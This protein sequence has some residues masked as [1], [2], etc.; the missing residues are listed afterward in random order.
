M[1]LKIVGELM[2]KY[3]WDEYYKKFYDWSK[4]KRAN[5]LHE[6]I[7]LGSVEEVGEII[8][9][10][11]ENISA[12]NS[13]LEKAVKAKLVF[14]GSYLRE[15]ACVNDK[16]LVAEATLNSFEILN[17]DE[18]ADILIE[19]QYSKSAFNRVLEKAVE[20]KIIFSAYSLRE[21]TETKNKKLV[22]DAIVNSLERLNADEVGEMIIELEEDIAASN[23]VLK[24]AV[25]EKLAFSGTH[26]VYFLYI[27]N[28]K[29]VGEAAINSMKR[30]N[31]NEVEEI[32][33]EFENHVSLTNRL[34]KKVVEAKLSLSGSCLCELV[35]VNNKNLVA[36]VI[37]NSFER[38]SADEIGE[39]IV[40]L[41]ENISASNKVLKQ[42]V[43]TKIVFSSA[44][45]NDFLYENDK[46]LVANATINSMSQLATDE[47]GKIIVELQDTISSSNRV[48]KKRLKQSI[49]FLLFTSMIFCMKIIRI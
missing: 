33:S 27:N 13:L 42:A 29:L 44:Y 25:E 35:E 11:E 49:L 21:L 37:M 47:V 16:E 26:L 10:F 41:A 22:A 20:E 1:K 14:S 31:T 9:E 23:C 39:M 17:A 34:L 28:K 6:L 46:S 2:G 19:L 32:L 40:E 7:S 5:N 12:S 8:G 4:S 24:K 18:I 38:L 45:L 36:E 15:F 30:L 3:T 48:L 43:E